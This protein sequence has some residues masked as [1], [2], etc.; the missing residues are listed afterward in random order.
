MNAVNAAAIKAKNDVV[1]FEIKRIEGLVGG[2]EHAIDDTAPFTWPVI[3]TI[4]RNEVSER[5]AGKWAN[6]VLER[7]LDIEA[8]R[9]D[10]FE[11]IS[12]SFVYHPY[13]V[14]LQICL[15]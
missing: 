3:V 12:A 7:R 13:S 8:G 15:C 1:I 5:F 9:V 2:I 6:S 10:V 4:G 14:E 11:E